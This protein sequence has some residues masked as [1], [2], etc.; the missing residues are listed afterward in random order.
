MVITH[1][2][3]LSTKG[4]C[5]FHNIT[6]NVTDAVRNSGLKNGIATVFTPS[7]TSAVTTVE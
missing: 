1:E 7:A 2:F 4:F 6:Q 5:D 3:N